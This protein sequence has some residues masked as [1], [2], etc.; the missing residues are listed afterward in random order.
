MSVNSTVASTR[1]IVAVDPG[2]G[3]ELLDLVD[4]RLD[5]ADVREGVSTGH[6]HQSRVRDVL[7]DVA[8][9]AVVLRIAGWAMEHEG[10]HVDRREH[11]PEIGVDAVQE[12]HAS[13]RRAHHA[14]A[15]AVEPRPELVVVGE[16]GQ[17]EPGRPA[18]VE[19]TRHD[20]FDSKLG[21]GVVLGNTE[22]VVRR[23]DPSGRGV[24]HHEVRD[25]VRVR[26]CE[27]GAHHAGGRLDREH[28]YPCG[29]GRV[30]HGH[31]VVDPALP[32]RRVDGGDRVGQAVTA[33]VAANDT[34]ERRQ[35]V[36]EASGQ[37]A[38]DLVLEV[39]AQAEHDEQVGRA[40]T[41]DLVRQVRLLFVKRVLRAGERH[42]G[43][44]IEVD[45]RC[46]GRLRTRRRQ[47]FVDGSC[48]TSRR[49]PEG[50]SNADRVVA[51]RVVVLGR[52][53]GNSVARADQ[54]RVQLLDIV[55]GFGMKREMVNAGAVPLVA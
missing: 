35:P 20:R 30:E 1:S 2:A 41:H 14:A 36:Q 42:A 23:L 4:D 6:L 47:G 25:P 38:L 48:T 27:H 16:A 26:G 54:L 24:V 46:P 55:A 50:S 19:P 51:G 8:N 18:V 44:L 32:R 40:V 29:L 10:G 33:P 3:H 53:C 39:Q 13:L 43:I 15:C 52:W 31:E 5:V 17:V 49:M 12:A 37:P 9:R 28:G 45:D 11:G 22:R 34:G 21:I 7:G